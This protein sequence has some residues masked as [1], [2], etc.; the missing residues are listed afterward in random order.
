VST[1]GE[2]PAS[3]A[4]GRYAFERLPS[5]QARAPE[6]EAL[7]ASARAGLAKAGFV[8]VE[9]G[10]QPDVL[11]QLGAQ[12]S[13]IA[14]PLWDDP[15]W[16]HGGFGLGGRGP[17]LA[18]RWGV[19]IRGYYGPYGPYSRYERYARQVALLIRDRATGQPL[20]EARAISEGSSPSRPAVLSAMF[21]AALKDFPKLGA[22]PRTVDVMM[23][24]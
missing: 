8:P 6:S 23:P 22:N 17:W 12:D 10:Q 9:A 1:F 13:G 24:R 16:W 4:P 18:T 3:R 7:E 15:M 5:Q 2:W 11:V 14:L 21:E 19:G 20:F